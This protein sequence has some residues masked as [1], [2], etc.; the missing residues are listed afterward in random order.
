MALTLELPHG[1]IWTHRAACVIISPESLG[2]TLRNVMN[3]SKTRTYISLIKSKNVVV[4]LLEIIGGTPYNYRMGQW[5]AVT[6]AAD[7]G[8]P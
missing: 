1:S 2:I 8:H 7:V 4:I 3:F 6:V 5:Q